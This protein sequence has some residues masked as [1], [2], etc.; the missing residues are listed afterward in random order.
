[1]PEEQIF[2][3]LIT[4]KFTTSQTEIFILYSTTRHVE[5]QIFTLKEIMTVK[6]SSRS[7]AIHFL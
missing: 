7:I 5:R 1:M 3:T 4:Q 6:S 2:L